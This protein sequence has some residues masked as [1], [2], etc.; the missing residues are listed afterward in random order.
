MPQLSKRA[1]SSI[2]Q[3]NP[4]L[5]T[6]SWPSQDGA[7]PAVGEDSSSLAVAV[8]PVRAAPPA[9]R[10]PPPRGTPPPPA[11]AGGMSA[12]QLCESAVLKA[13]RTK[14]ANTSREVVQ[15]WAGMNWSHLFLGQSEVVH[16]NHQFLASSLVLR[17]FIARVCVC[18]C[19]CAYMCCVC[20]CV[21]CA[22]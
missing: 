17:H 10:W 15:E 16:L 18:V 1:S 2:T 7:C 11:A 8:S 5:T 3:N 6:R 13:G 20:A 12:P 4:S 22:M 9:D 21:V 19:M 14:G